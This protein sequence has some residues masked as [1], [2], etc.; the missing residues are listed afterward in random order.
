M[1]LSAFLAQYAGLLGQG[2][3]DTLVMVIGSTAWAYLVGIALGV[4]LVVLAP[5]G[6][7]P[8]RRAYA[9]L[10]WAINML[11]SLPFIILMV[12]ISPFTRAVVGTSLGVRAAI[13]PLVVS[14]GPF[15]AR[16]VEQSLAEVDSRLVEAA[17]SMGASTGEIIVKVYLREGL[18]SLLRGLPIVTIT[19]LGYSAMAGVTGAG[20]LGDIA[21]RYGY[22]RYQN[23]VMVA[24]ILILVVLV[25]LIQTIGNLLVRIFD[26]RM[27]S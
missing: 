22:Q 7:H 25:Q 13:V 1:D 9:V 12:F 21:I 8:H 24:T 19:I 20:G 11:R 16:M 14:A 17:A 27:R 2:T 15:V 18:P 6:L 4:L 3:L 10:G 5:G 23:D 26:R